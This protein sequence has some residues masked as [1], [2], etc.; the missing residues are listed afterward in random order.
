MIDLKTVVKKEKQHLFQVNHASIHGRQANA[1]TVMD[2]EAVRQWAKSG[3][4]VI[5]S[6]RMMPSEISFAKQLVQKLARQNTCCLMVKPYT[7][8]AASKLPRELIQYADNLGYPLFEIDEDATYMQIMNDVNTLLFQDRRTSKMAD[9]D[10]DY[11]LKT[12]SVSDKDFDFISGLKGVDLYKLEARVIRV[13]L[14]QIPKSSE[15]MMIQYSLISQLQTTFSSLAAKQKIVTDFILES[16]NGA[17]IVLFFKDNQSKK[18]PY[19]RRYYHQLLDTVK[20]P[21]FSLYEGVA[22]LHKAK[23]LHRAFTEAGFGMD[24]A[25]TMNWQDRPIFYR[26]VSLWE[27]VNQLSKIQDSRLYPIEMDQILNN[28]EIFETVQQFFNHNES[29]TE[30][31]KALYTHPNTIRY[32]LNMIYKQTGLDYRST[33]DKFLIYIALIE[34]LLA[35]QSES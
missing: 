31:G 6:S 28:P 11:L 3:E 14:A 34:K 25:K 12:N 10:L 19:D 26:D 27:L 15:R 22:G 24:V 5:T 33:N 13:S 23:N 20:I 4:I 16:T 30:T 7:S 9:L 17:T 32:R 2:N 21:H 29:I 35:N 1:I 8:E 18:P